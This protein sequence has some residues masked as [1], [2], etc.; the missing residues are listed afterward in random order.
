MKAMIQDV[1]MSDGDARPEVVLSG[2]PRVAECDLSFTV[3]TKLLCRCQQS[4][5]LLVAVASD[6]IQ[7]QPPDRDALG[8][9]KLTASHPLCTQPPHYP[10]S[11]APH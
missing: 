7:L 6:Y 2:S 9:V 8:R 10:A 11:P 1:N 4:T 5:E 3:A